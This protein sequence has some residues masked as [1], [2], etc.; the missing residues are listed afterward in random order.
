MDDELLRQLYHRLFSDPSFV[1]TRDCT[2]GDAIILLIHF[3]AVLDNRS[4]LWASVKRNWPLWCRALRFRTPF[5]A[6][7]GRKAWTYR[8]GGGGSCFRVRMKA[9]CSAPRSR[10][11]PRTS[12]FATWKSGAARASGCARASRPR[13]PRICP[14]GAAGLTKP[15]R[16]W[17]RTPRSCGYGRTAHGAWLGRGAKAWDLRANCVCPIHCLSLRSVREA[18]GAPGNPSRPIACCSRRETGITPGRFAR[19]ACIN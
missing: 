1:H 3:F 12:P 9:A 13:S 2:F 16:S 11:W 14:R 19:P 10:G 18:C 15:C 6:D 8:I 5:L 4:H 17:V 7:R